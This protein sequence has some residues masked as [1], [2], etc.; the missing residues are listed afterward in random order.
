MQLI[1]PGQ[2]SLKIETILEFIRHLGNLIIK[3]GHL[4][5]KQSNRERFK[6]EK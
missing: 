5:K 2:F 3:F 4:Y 6:T 1:R